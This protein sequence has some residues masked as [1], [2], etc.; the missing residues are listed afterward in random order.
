[1]SQPEKT[2]ENNVKKFLH[3]VGI[4]PAGYAVHKMTVPPVGWYFKVWGGGYQKSGIPDLILN[5]NGLFVGVELKAENGRPSELQ[6]YNIRA[7]RNAHGIAFVLYPAAFEG[8][9]TIIRKLIQTPATIYY[10]DE[11][12]EIWKEC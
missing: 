2:F 3:T 10:R 7:I 5:V 12:P 1:M 6:L 4:Y 9:K 11:M 8:F